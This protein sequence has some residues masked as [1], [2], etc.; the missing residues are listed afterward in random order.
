M[1][2]RS[3]RSPDDTGKGPAG[4][5]ARDSQGN[6]VWEWAASAGRQ[7]LDSTSRLLKRLD[8]PGLKLL[9]EDGAPGGEAPGAKPAAKPGKLQLPQERARQGF[10]P[11]EGRASAA[12]PAPKAGAHPQGA[13]APVKPTKKPSLLDRL[14]GRR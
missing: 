7:A 4:H 2:E 11:Y 12:K 1:D 13:K 6:A 5:V 9:D 10:D 14:L 8:V 3:R